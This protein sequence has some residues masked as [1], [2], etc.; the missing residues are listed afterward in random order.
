MRV[1][2]WAGLILIQQLAHTKVPNGAF[3]IAQNT[4]QQTSETFKE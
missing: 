3:F 1:S 4:N 2:G